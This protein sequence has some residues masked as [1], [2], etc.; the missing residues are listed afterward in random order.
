VSRRWID[1]TPDPRPET[2]DH[3]GVTVPGGVQEPDNAFPPEACA[4]A[5]WTESYTGV[6][7]WADQSCY[8]NVSLMCKVK[9]EW[10]HCRYLMYTR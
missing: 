9:R 2:Y 4:T 7:G 6:W 8:K 1:K 5:N 10:Q 3:W